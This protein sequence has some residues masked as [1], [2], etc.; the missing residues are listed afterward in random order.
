MK[1]PKCNMPNS[2]DSNFCIYRGNKF[3]NN[4][5]SSNNKIFTFLKGVPK[6]PFYYG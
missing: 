4:M 2:N 5:E 6:N 1:R 3:E